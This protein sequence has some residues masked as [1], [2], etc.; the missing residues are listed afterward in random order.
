MRLDKIRLN[1]TLKLPV[2][3]QQVRHVRVAI[4]TGVGQRGVARACKRVRVISATS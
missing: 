4:L 2:L 1:Y 3:Q